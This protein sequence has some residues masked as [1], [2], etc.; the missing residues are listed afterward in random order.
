MSGVAGN[1]VG[2]PRLTNPSLTY[3]EQ[4]APPSVDRRIQPVTQSN[5]LSVTPNHPPR[6][7]RFAVQRGAS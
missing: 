7:H 3:Q 2:E 5:E 4:S 6:Q 1:H